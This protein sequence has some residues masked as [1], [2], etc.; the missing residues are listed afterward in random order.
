MMG[1][2]S[3][4]IQMRNGWKQNT[5]SQTLLLHKRKRIKKNSNIEMKGFKSEM[6]GSKRQTQ[7]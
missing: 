1:F 4:G 6:G 5:D 3:E 7:I 2:K